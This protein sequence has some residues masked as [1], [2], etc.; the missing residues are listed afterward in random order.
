MA[1]LAPRSRR[2]IACLLA[3]AVLSGLA[4]GRADAQ[5][6]SVIDVKAA[7]LYN[8][9]KFTEWPLDALPVGGR[10]EL[11]VMGDVPIADA[12]ERTIKGRTIEGHELAVRVVDGS[13]T[14]PCHL[15]YVNGADSVRLAHQIERLRG[16]S[17]L[18]VSDGARFAQGGG[19][20]QL[21]LE[22]ERMLFTINVTAADR[23]R[24]RLSSKLLGLARIVRDGP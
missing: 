11:C 17:V 19:I 21:R 3:A 7:F 9:A 13:E 10:L 22:N 8:F 5:S 1:L 18:T 2:L 14:A 15:L 23:A 20:V 6:A 16:K 4:A 24:L 12:L